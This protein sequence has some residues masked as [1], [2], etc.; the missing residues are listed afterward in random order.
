MFSIGVEC[1]F[2]KTSPSLAASNFSALTGP[3]AR[4][5]SNRVQRWSLS[6]NVVHISF[7]YNLAVA[8][9]INCEI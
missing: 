5:P 6:T 9:S 7:C 2:V 4:G 3:K 8:F 1:T